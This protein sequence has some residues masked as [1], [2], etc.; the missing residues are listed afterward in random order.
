MPIH[1]SGLELAYDHI[2][3]EEVVTFTKGTDTHLNIRVNPQRRSLKAIL[4][5]FVE[6]YAAEARE[7]EKHF[8]PDITKVTVIVNG[9][10]NRLY[11]NSIYVKNM[12][13]EI[14]RFLGKTQRKGT[15]VTKSLADNKFGLFINLSSMAD[16]S[17]HGRSIR[18][19]STKYSVHLEIERSASSSGN[20]NCHI[21]VIS[22]S[23]QLQP[24]QY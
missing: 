24:V 4:L 15:N 10:P 17:M 6:P 23:Y 7:S 8:N 22:D 5:L 18:L 12:W 21:F 2:M 14:S 20:V 13:D 9:S 11:N 19:V 3:R 1:S 16:S